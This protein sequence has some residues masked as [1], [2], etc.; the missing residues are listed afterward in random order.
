MQ[1]GGK[2]SKP[3]PGASGRAS[4]RDGPSADKTGT[5]GHAKPCKT[6]T[7][8][9]NKGAAFGGNGPVFWAAYVFPACGADAGYRGNFDGFKDSGSAF[10]GMGRDFVPAGKGVAKKSGGTETG[11]GLPDRTGIRKKGGQSA[12]GKS[13]TA[14]G[15]CQ[16]CLRTQQGC[17]G[18]PGNPGGASGRISCQSCF[19]GSLQGAGRKETRL[20]AGRKKFQ[21]RAGE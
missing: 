7:G 11:P 4:K 14:T 6:G 12:A 17:A 5:G 15:R 8:G 1:A 16:R 9:R 13:G 19:T 3:D 20:R 2:P 21:E 18:K 10:G